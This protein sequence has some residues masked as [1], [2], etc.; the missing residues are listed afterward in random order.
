MGGTWVMG[1]QKKGNGMCRDGKDGER[2]GTQVTGTQ[3]V[4]VM[5]DMWDMKRR[6]RKDV[7]HKGHAGDTGHNTWGM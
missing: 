1:T 3:R 2:K 5:G 6:D 4:A 7:G